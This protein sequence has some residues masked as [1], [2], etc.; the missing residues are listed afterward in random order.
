MPLLDVEPLDRVVSASVAEQRFSLI[1]LG[2]FGLIALALGAAGL[3]GVMSHT[4]A[5]K[6]RE[7]GVRIAVGAQRRDILWMVMREAGLLIE[8]GLITGVV[9]S[10]A[11]A[12]LLRS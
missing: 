12:R 4:V 10:L 7:I 11:G 5:R 8:I 1:L 9:A 3:Y 2:G 6:T